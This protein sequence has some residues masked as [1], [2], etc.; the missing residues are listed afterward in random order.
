M[1][2]HPWVGKPLI[3]TYVTNMRTDQIGSFNPPVALLHPSSSQCHVTTAS[4]WSYLQSQGGPGGTDAG[5]CCRNTM[6]IDWQPT[7]TCRTL[8]CASGDGRGA[9]PEPREI[10]FE[11]QTVNICIFY[12]C[13]HQCLKVTY[14][15]TRCGL[16]DKWSTFATVHWVGW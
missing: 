7:S 8:W 6:S 3:P 16:I 9:D 4:T 5:H 10:R 14:Y 13:L 1:V 15:T 11:A 12:K 2:P